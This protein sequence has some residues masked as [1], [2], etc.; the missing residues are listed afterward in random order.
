MACLNGFNVIGTIDL[1]DMAKPSCLSD[2]DLWLGAVPI[3]Q[4]KFFFTFK[5]IY[6]ILAI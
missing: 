5:I 3:N 6:E 1:T 4:V 2:V